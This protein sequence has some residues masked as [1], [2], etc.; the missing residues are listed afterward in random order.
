MM[1]SNK[2]F[3][4]YFFEAFMLLYFEQYLLIDGSFLKKIK[5]VEVRKIPP[6]FNKNT[7]QSRKVQ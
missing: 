3:F 1:Q 6:L 5:N 2:Y 4:Y 7:D